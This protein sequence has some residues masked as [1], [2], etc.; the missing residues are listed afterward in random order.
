M[1][2]A[3][4]F[5]R[6]RKAKRSSLAS[7]SLSRDFALLSFAIILILLLISA[8]VAYVTYV[9]HSETTMRELGVAARRIDMTLERELQNAGFLLTGAGRVVAMENPSSK[10]DV[11]RLVKALDAKNP[12][13][14]LFA[15]IDATKH[16]VVS[17]NKGILDVPVDVADRDYVA[18]AQEEPWQVQIGTPIEGRV[19]E[20]WVIPVAIGVTDSTGRFMGTLMVS[21]DINSF[22]GY[23][24]TL[25]RREGVHFAIYSKNFVPLTRNI[26][27]SPDIIT[28][29]ERLKHID[30]DHDRKGLLAEANVFGANNMFAY[31][32]VSTHFPYV[33]L[34]TYEGKQ[35]DDAIRGMLWP[36][37]L[38]IVVI[39]IFLLSFLWMI[40]VRIIQPVETLT[41][42]A[43]AIP[44]GHPFVLPSHTGPLEIEALADEL[45]RIDA[46]VAEKLKVEKELRYKLEE[47]ARVKKSDE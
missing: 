33:I 30:L 31:Y 35:S 38:Q 44:A 14:S 27:T 25:T 36:R 39:A 29:V 32:E 15:W 20:R 24:D 8:W 12:G 22:T 45:V 4:P 40:R 7:P 21:V 28:A 47:A 13:L 17:S 34:L 1:P 43:S 11:A 46:Y 19:S 23:L 6:P 42:A 10:Q 2:P 41:K 18:K 16:L 3:A 26:T 9:K 37:L 5:P